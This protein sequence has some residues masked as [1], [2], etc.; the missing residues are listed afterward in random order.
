MIGGPGVGTLQLPAPGQMIPI[1]PTALPPLHALFLD[2]P[3]PALTSIF[4]IQLSG[5]CIRMSSTCRQL[6]CVDASVVS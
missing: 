3:L 5:S 6:T 4:S 1:H 2:L